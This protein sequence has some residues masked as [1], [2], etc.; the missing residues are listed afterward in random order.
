[1]NT[2]GI[3][4]LAGGAIAGYL[5]YDK[6]IKKNGGETTE[7][8][9]GRN[10]MRRP[11]TQKAVV[12]SSY[13]HCCCQDGVTGFASLGVKCSDLQDYPA[14]CKK[15]APVMKQPRASMNTS[16]NPFRK[17]MKNATR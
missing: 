3:I 4:M 16:E 2:R 12:N 8:F 13:E 17:F 7:S 5:I 1:M 6:F 15:C 9:T 11:T 14:P 10:R